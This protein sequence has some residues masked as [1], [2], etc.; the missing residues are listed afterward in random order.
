MS[1]FYFLIYL[2]LHYKFLP[3]NMRYLYIPSKF[4][5]NIDL[6]NAQTEAMDYLTYK[7]LNKRIYKTF[8]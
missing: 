6:K 4:S 5:K 1:N 7:T 2:N 8:C 3:K